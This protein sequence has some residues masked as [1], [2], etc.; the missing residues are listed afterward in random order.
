MT[1]RSHHVSVFETAQRASERR[2]W[3]AQDR[4]ARV[5]RPRYSFAQSL[6]SRECDNPNDEAKSRH[7]PRQSIQKQIVLVATMTRSHYTVI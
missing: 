6:P 7:N 3:R 1:I 2:F 5:E 4:H